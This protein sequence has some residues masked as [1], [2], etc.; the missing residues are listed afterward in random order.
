M[1]VRFKPPREL[2]ATAAAEHA[3]E[4]VGG[5]E[6]P[7]RAAAAAQAPR[8]RARGRRPRPRA[9]SRRRCARRLRRRARG[10]GG[11]GRPRS[12]RAA[13]ALGDGAANG[14]GGMASDD[15]S[16]ATLLSTL[17]DGSV[18]AH[19]LAS[20]IGSATTWHTAPSSTRRPR[21]LPSV[22]GVAPDVV[23]PALRALALKRAASTQSP[24]T[25]STRACASSSATRP[26]CGAPR[27][28]ARLADAGGG[29]GRSPLARTPRGHG[30]AATRAISPRSAPRPSASLLAVERVVRFRKC[31][32][33]TDF[34]RHV[35]RD[36]DPERGAH[37][38]AR[39]RALSLRELWDGPA[40]VRGYSR[41]YARKAL[42]VRGQARG[43]QGGEGRGR[44]VRRGDGR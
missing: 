23:R 6:R 10:D 33:L 40:P 43:A 25:S 30:R 41:I 18:G 37:R 19:S 3:D 39:S 16:D 2:N 13:P 20:S 11:G 22:R 8:R 9:A 29:G 15:A 36:V 35:A 31:M 32:A 1:A 27:G 38:R 24:A 7:A 5:A 34:V 44:G 28:A 21:A 14:G 26:R 17:D 12:R 42:G 4:K